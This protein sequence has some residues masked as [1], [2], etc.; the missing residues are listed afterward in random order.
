MD[1]LTIGEMAGINNVSTQTLRLY[2]RS[3]LLSPEH[4]NE[5]TGYR[6]YSIKQSAKLDMIQYMKSLGMSLKEIKEQLD[7]QDVDVVKSLLQKHRENIEQQMKELKRT[8]NAVDR[9]IASYNRYRSAPK[10]GI[11]VTEYMPRRRIYCFDSGIN[12]YDYGI[13]TYEQILRELKSHLMS[14]ELPLIY[15]CN[16]GTLLRFEHLKKREFIS[17]ETFLFVDEDFSAIDATQLIEENTYLC[18]YCDSFYKEKEFA[19]R[20]FDYAKNNDIT[21]TGDYICEVVMELPVFHYNER[22]MLIKLQV[23]IKYI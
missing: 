14:Y 9:S 20:L 12:F 11:I 4:I 13:E 17:T 21:I 19:N 2:D 5:E 6:Y 15:F 10:P 18:I 22:N 1:R 3:G 7:K 16:V 23:P 8:R